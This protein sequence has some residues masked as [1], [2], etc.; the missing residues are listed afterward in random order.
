MLTQ[1]DVDG[2]MAGPD[3]EL[4]RRAGMLTSRPIIA[5]GGVR[6]KADLTQLVRAGVEAAIVGKAI[7]EGTVDL[8]GVAEL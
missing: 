8:A 3:L 4:Y 1:I 5:S 6:N 2:T 7:Y